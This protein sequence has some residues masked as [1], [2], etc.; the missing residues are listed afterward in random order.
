MTDDVIPLG[1]PGRDD[2]REA[3]LPEHER[4]DERTAG[5]GLMSSGG[6]AIERGTDTIDGPDAP[7]RRRRPA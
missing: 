4:D 7:G 1:P 5:G 2:D 6:T 3:E